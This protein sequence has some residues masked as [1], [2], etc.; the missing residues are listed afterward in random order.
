MNFLMVLIMGAFIGGASGYI[1]SLMVTKRMA[2]TGGALGHLTLPGIALGVIYGFDV[3]IGAFVFLAF[4]ITLIWV[5]KT[6]SEL[7]ME[8]ITAVVFASSVSIA[9]L[10][11]PEQ[12]AVPALI[13]DASRIT[14]VPTVV[15]VGL[16][17]VI[18]VLTKKIYP[19]M[20]L[21]SLSEDVAISEGYDVRKYDFIYL[22]G[23]AL[24]VAL[25][26]RVVGSLLT[27]ALVAIPA[28]ASRNLSNNHFQYSYGAL[29]IGILSSV[30]GI[31]VYEFVG[32][33]FGLVE[34]GSPGPYIIITSSIFF[35][36]SLFTKR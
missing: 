20:V 2:L 1:G 15:T 35:V 12:E 32:A 17:L 13:G 29:A 24:T 18:L 5:F 4:G 25:G 10:F 22:F 6:E 14:L 28:S 8:A 16:S 36:I 34:I 33:P 23:I 7:P 31:L 21:S 30:V 9:F 19:K 27:A 3:S 11:L 26:V